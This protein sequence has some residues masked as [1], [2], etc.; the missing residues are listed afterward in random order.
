[1]TVHL[2]RH[3]KAGSRQRWD[4]PDD[5]RPLSKRGRTQAAAMAAR[6]ADAPIEHVFSSPYLRCVE[7]VEPLASRLGT[8]VE[9][10]DGLAEGAPLAEALRLLE[11]VGDRT[12]VLCT[13]GDVLGDVIGHAARHGVRLDGEGYEKGC[14]WELELEAGAIVS[15]RYLPAPS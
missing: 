4:G 14:T 2:V 11:K 12:V 10:A 6:L 15:A 1:M 7:T 9:A 3:A 8:R 5:R 13:H